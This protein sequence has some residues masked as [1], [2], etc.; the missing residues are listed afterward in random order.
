M[1]KRLNN[2][3]IRIEFP[4][5]VHGFASVIKITS[6]LNAKIFHV[7]NNNI[8]NVNHK[9]NHKNFMVQIWNS[10]NELIQPLNI[11]RTDFDCIIE[12][13]K[14]IT[15]TVYLLRVLSDTVNQLPSSDWIKKHGMMQ[16]KGH[17]FLQ[18][19]DNNDT[20]IVP[21]IEKRID[22]DLN[23]STD[24]KIEMLWNENQIEGKLLA[25]IHGYR[26]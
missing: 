3:S 5:K 24:N 23:H 2:K 4:I 13:H 12:F 26:I 9:Y 14:N 8:L 6:I 22:T 19:S 16:D 11:I 17:I 15:A 10:D 20:A 7:F 25:I 21:S 1:A 18:A